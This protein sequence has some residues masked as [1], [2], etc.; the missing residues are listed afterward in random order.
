M[1][2]NQCKIFCAFFILGILTGFIF[3]FF[4][5]LRKSIKTSNIITYVQDV[6]FFLVIG[7]MFLK[8]IIIFSSGEIRLYIFIAMIFGII[9]Y[10]LT[11]GNLC[12]IIFKV[13]LDFLKKI[14]L[15]FIRII[16]IPVKIIKNILLK[17]KNIKKKNKVQNN[18]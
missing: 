15:C 16:K 1:I 6:V 4:R 8:S 3:D 2:E 18:S 5:A 14:I 17:L 9:I 13:I 7:I 12:A 10:I 11:I